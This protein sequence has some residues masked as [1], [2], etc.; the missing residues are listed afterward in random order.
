[1]KIVKAILRIIGYIL[2]V[3]IL[4]V[5][6]IAIWHH[7]NNNITKKNIT[8]PGDRIEI[9]DNEYIHAVKMGT[10]DY[11]IVMLPG[12]GTPS[13]YYDYYKLATEISKNNQVIVMEPLGYGYSDNTE[14][15]R[16]LKNYNYELSKVLEYYSIN[17]NI[18][19][20]GHSYS[21]I[22]NFNYAKHH[23]E[24]KGIICLDC[25]NARQIETHVKDGKFKEKVPKQPSIYSIVSPLGITR[26]VYS[27]FLAK[28]VEKKLLVDVPNEYH[29][30]YKYFLF[31]KTLNK[32]I[33]NEVNGIY[34]NQLEILEDKYRED[35]YV[36]TILSDETIKEM[37]EYKEEGDFDHDWE[38]MHELLITNPE[39]QKIH[40][41]KGDHYIHH[42]NV[43]EINELITKMIEEMGKEAKN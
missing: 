32:T 18:I 25:T 35:L 17:N 28:D 20:L 16:S 12:M 24:I 26:F 2:F 43:K 5:I 29:D 8:V 13:P 1:M 36:L 40:T 22:S 38:E 21:G 7:I 42:N 39:I 9:Y 3:L 27:T 10:G 15:D 14:K 34:Y 41:L 6:I 37:K 31:N 33:I 4:A 19:L 23:E 30:A 11:T